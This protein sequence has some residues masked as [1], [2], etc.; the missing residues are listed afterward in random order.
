MSAI[1]CS[2]LR[3]AIDCVGAFAR[4]W[5]QTASMHRCTCDARFAKLPVNGALKSEQG[6]KSS[7]AAASRIDRCRT[8]LL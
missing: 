1:R 5:H 6:P 7:P 3:A 4:L 8:N 2:L